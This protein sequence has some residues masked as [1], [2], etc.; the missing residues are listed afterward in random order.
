MYQ[1]VQCGLAIEHFEAILPQNVDVLVH[2]LV[3]IYSHVNMEAEQPLCI[4]TQ[5][6]VLVKY[7]ESF[8][9]VKSVQSY[10]FIRIVPKEKAYIFE[11]S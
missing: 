10:T 7:H 3:G 1:F 5:L 8:V 9:F 11:K 4:L 6:F 2:S